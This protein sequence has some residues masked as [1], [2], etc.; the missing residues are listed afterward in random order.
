MTRAFCIF[1]LVLAGCDSK[2]AE[3][4]SCFRPQENACIQYDAARAAAGKRLCVGLTW[5]AGAASCPPANRLGTCAKKDATELLY[6]GPPNNY[7]AAS[8]KLACEHAP[9]TFSELK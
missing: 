3:P 4:G 8:A 6:A 2:P 1:L 7:N 9:G 5:T